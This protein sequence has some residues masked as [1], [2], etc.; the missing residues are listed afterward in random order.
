VY[1]HWTVRRLSPPSN[2]LAAC[3]VLVSA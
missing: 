3:D 1:L 2:E